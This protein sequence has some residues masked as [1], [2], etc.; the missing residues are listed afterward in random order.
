MIARNTTGRLHRRLTRDDQEDTGLRV[1]VFGLGYVGCVSAA[2]LARDG[3]NVIGVDVNPWKVEQVA[4]GRSPVIEAGLDDLMAMAVGS[5]RL[6]ATTD[7][8]AAVAN[9][10]ISVV[11]VGTPS[12]GNG[13]LGLHYVERVSREIGT[14][15][16][17][18]SGYHVVVV[19]STVLP[20][21]VEEKVIPILE[22]HSHRRR[23]TDVGVCMNPEFLREG[24][25]IE[26]YYHP[27]H[28]VIGE[29]DRRS[30]DV[31]ERLYEAV[32]APH[33][34]TA[35]R[36]AEMAKYVSNS[37]HAL[38]IAFANEIGAICEEQ[39]IDAQEVMGIFFRD[40]RLNISTAYLQPGFAFGGSCLP[41]DLRALLYR[42]REIDLETPLLR[43]VLDSN[44]RQIQRAVALVE[45]TG[46]K[47][48]GV[49]GLSFKP[50][51]DDVRE[52]PAVPLIETLIGR[53][54]QV[55]VYDENVDPQALVGANRSYL[56]R[57]LPHIASI[58]LPSIREV[59]GRSEVVVIAQ[60]S[61]SFRHVRRLLR[62]DQVL[63]DLAAAAGLD[64]EEPEEYEEVA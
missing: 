23:G 13:S 52:S 42:S 46:R 33:V 12:N 40:N 28:I 62:K 61:P 59:V 6:Q 41:K 20:G 1:S 50:G 10:D 8:A 5:G 11:C 63:V 43:A 58:M 45:K 44:Q 18:K 48:V 56:E 60:G 53:G 27:S 34:R 16:A 64:P 7:S 38:K 32:E 30:G 29:M 4:S 9:S 22:S 49:L 39:G 2:C 17:A 14:A 51:T 21:T 37:F 54:Y 26:D 3:H 25:A 31:A 24:K 57:A 35:I 55:L 15:L 19:R 36:V 47:R